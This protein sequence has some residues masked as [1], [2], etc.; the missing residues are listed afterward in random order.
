M[1]DDNGVESS[2]VAR[3]GQ[4]TV[5]GPRPQGDSSQRDD[6]AAL[7]DTVDP[8]RLFAPTSGSSLDKQL[9]RARAEARLLGE[10]S[11]RVE[12]GRFSVVDRLG[13]GAMG[14]VYE[15]YDPKLDRRVALKLVDPSRLGSEAGNAPARL[16]REARA[17]ADLSHPNIVTVYDVGI[18]EGGVFLAMEYVRGTTLTEWMAPQSRSW[19]EVVEMFTEIGNGLAAAH[20]AGIVHRDF[21]PDNVLVGLDGRPR[22]ADFGLARPVEGWT[23]REE[24]ATLPR[25]G[26]DISS[27]L[28]TTGEVCGTPAYMAPEQF[29]GQDVGPLSDQFAFCVALFEALFGFRPF[30]GSS[31]TA[32]ASRVLEGQTEPLPPNH[33]VP[34]EVLV[35]VE[36]GLDPAP[37]HRHEGMA[38]LVARL[39]DVAR[40]RRRRAML[41]G[42]VGLAGVALA[43][44]YQVSAASQIDPCEEVDA[45]ISAAWSDD[46][47]EAVAA[48]AT[49][50]VV[51]ALDAYADQWR[52]QRR[53]A[54]EATRVHG[55]QS[56]FALE[57]R[58]A[59]LDQAAARMQGIAEEL[60]VS[61][62]EEASRLVGLV[63]P[64]EECADIERLEQ[65]GDALRRGTMSPRQIEAQR[66]GSSI[67]ARAEAR[68]LSG[69]P[70]AR[71]LFVEALGEFEQAE[72][73]AAQGVAHAKLAELAIADGDL[74][75]ADVHVQAATRF[76]LS[77]GHDEQAADVALLAS[78]IALERGRDD[79]ADLHLQY[80]EGLAE[81]AVS[82]G[83]RELLRAR[84]TARRAALLE[85]R[86]DTTR[87]LRLIDAALDVLATHPQ[88]PPSLVSS[89]Y[90]L[91]GSIRMDE[92]DVAGAVDALQAAL[93]HLARANVTGP[94]EAFQRIN[95]AYALGLMHRF[96]DAEKEYQRATEI[97]TPVFGTEHVAIA[98]ILTSQGWLALEAGDVRL[99]TERLERADAIFGRATPDGHPTWAI[100]LDNLADVDRRDANYDAALRKLERAQAIRDR[101]YG[102][103]HEDQAYSLVFVARVHADAG[104]LEQAADAAARALEVF[105]KP[106]ASPVDLAEAEL[107]MARAVAK[108]DP[109]Q[110][111]ALASSAEQR[112]PKDI[113]QPTRFV[114]DYEK[115]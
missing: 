78:F 88:A 1:T 58:M 8:Q 20:A 40:R 66:E 99:A 9:A 34:R 16:E 11:T 52:G 12:I 10:S 43:G 18:H 22:I 69:R 4:E 74:D 42:A 108:S 84:V 5:Q 107:V 104:A 112:L 44:G 83:K 63:R 81:R 67:M 26:R 6:P 93:E 55:E 54:C 77:T 33:K 91:A 60:S 89:A 23:A 71:E 106:G 45:P 72:F 68:T 95:L 73:S 48:A 115:L 59:C 27:I 28:A 64:L 110:S 100:V 79:A 57:L 102:K 31:I 3:A 50:D 98:T 39:Q 21:K 85:Y 62:P 114:E 37:E 24:R 51:E 15:G 2:A 53:Q 30:K 32:L 75:Q 35:L 17:A 70:G 103:S 14:V 13:Q 105:R 111:S 80:A 56:D 113:P 87:A 94:E 36:R 49:P 97:L 19:R 7:A 86:G 96:E 25:G 38:E 90:S 29:T 61:T 65:V 82:D 41:A 46:G 101:V 47:R 76:A 92:A 109:A